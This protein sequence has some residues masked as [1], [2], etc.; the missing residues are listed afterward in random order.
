ML[1]VILRLISAIQ[2]RP[3]SFQD[4]GLDLTMPVI[5]VNLGDEVSESDQSHLGYAVSRF[6]WACLVSEIKNHFYQFTSSRLSESTR[7][8]LQSD[9]LA[10]LDAWLADAERNVESLDKPHTGPLLTKARIDYHYAVGLL[11]QPS[12][13]CPRPDT[14]ALRHCFE[15][16]TKRVH[17]FWSLYEEKGLILSWPTA[18]GIS[19]AGTM[20]AYCVWTSEE[21]RASLSVATL[22]ADLQ[23]C[24]S[25]LTLGGEWW[26]SARVGGRSFQRLANL[27]IHSLFSSGN[28]AAGGGMTSRLP[29]P[30][31]PSPPND[32]VLGIPGR[33]PTNAEEGINVDDL[34]YSFLQNGFDMTDIP[35]DLNSA[36]IPGD[37]NH[38]QIP[39]D[40]NP[41]LFDLHTETSW[42]PTYRN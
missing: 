37:L 36:Q 34:L 2:G 9:I 1:I 22:S 8:S 6:R 24:S 19:L 14:A 31:P 20:L 38:A 4:D 41:A 10:R 40:L 3:S 28:R 26:E 29:S 21:I 15:S 23:L 11:Y 32:N 33:L 30:H 7:L 13:A 27:T 25:L 18:Q 5:L 12:H 39:G 35:G 42:E 17:L 16:A